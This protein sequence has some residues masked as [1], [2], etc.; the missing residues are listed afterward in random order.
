[1]AWL[2]VQLTEEQQRVVSE[3][4]TSHPNERIRERMLVL[5]LLHTELHAERRLRSSGSDERPSS[6]LWPRFAMEG[7][8]VCDDGTP[9]APRAKWLPIAS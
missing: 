6:G 4:R 8:M 9:I 3:E 1:M 5:W 7:W 2:H